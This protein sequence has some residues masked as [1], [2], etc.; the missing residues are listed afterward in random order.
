MWLLTKC[1]GSILTLAITPT[2][3]K[4]EYQV[5]FETGTVTACQAQVILYSS[6]GK[7]IASYK[8]KKKI[9]NEEYRNFQRVDMVL[10]SR[11]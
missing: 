4:G 2:F 5:S 1:L 6:N 11:P 8:S 9:A 3:T 10:K 7:T